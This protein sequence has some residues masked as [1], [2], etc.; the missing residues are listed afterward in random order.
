VV[1]LLRGGGEQ[2]VCS[3]LVYFFFLQSF[4]PHSLHH[5]PKN[6]RYWQKFGRLFLGK[7]DTKYN[8]QEAIFINI[9]AA[10]T[11]TQLLVLIFVYNAQLKLLFLPLLSK[12][13]LINQNI[14]KA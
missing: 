1:W 4:H 12:K 11:E 8:C 7:T 10:S 14:T 2:G 9:K 3:G 13:N 6:N 5:S